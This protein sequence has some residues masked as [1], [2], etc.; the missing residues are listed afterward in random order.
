M[1]EKLETHSAAEA[2]F[3][4]AADGAAAVEE[5]G[6]AVFA[7]TGGGTED[8]DERVYGFF[9]LFPE[10]LPCFLGS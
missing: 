7:C 4:G 5:G 2:G 9:A 1:I 6:V 8:V 10:Y 3:G